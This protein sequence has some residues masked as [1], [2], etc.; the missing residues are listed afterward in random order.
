MKARIEFKRQHCWVGVYWKR[1]QT[2]LDHI[3]QTG[4]RYTDVWVC[5]V[6]MFPIHISNGPRYSS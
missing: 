4:N 5:L 6:P 1:W 2:G 3:E